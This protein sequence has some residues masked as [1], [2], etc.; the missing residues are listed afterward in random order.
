MN[1]SPKEREEKKKNNNIIFE[2][3]WGHFGGFLIIH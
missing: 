2:G 1:S 3:F